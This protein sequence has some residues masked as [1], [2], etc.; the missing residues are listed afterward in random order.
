[1]VHR[2]S[3]NANLACLR[4]GRW[5]SNKPVTHGLNQGWDGAGR[6]RHTPQQQG[7]RDRFTPSSNCTWHADP[8]RSS[9]NEMLFSPLSVGLWH[10][11]SNK[12]VTK[13][14]EAC[15]VGKAERLSALSQQIA[16]REAF[17]NQNSKWNSLN[18]ETDQEGLWRLPYYLTPAGNQSPQCQTSLLTA[19]IVFQQQFTQI[20]IRH[21]RTVTPKA[22][23]DLLRQLQLGAVGALLRLQPHQVGNRSIQK[24]QERGRK[25]G[26]V[27]MLP[28]KREQQRCD[29]L[30]HRHQTLII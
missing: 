25:D 4:P 3:I 30:C 15:D 22:D 6:T 12:R 29:S 8:S 5:S 20:L 13:P 17:R 7:D 21:F 23:T 9:L 26:D 24:M 27:H 11:Q 16:D 18:S 2:H 10:W 1:M 14:G 28:L 19:G